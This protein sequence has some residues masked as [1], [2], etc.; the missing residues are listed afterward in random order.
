[1]HG[2]CAPLGELAAG[3][4][5]NATY[6]VYRVLNGMSINEIKNRFFYGRSLIF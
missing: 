4:R 3:L 6:F 1:M 2:T 5:G